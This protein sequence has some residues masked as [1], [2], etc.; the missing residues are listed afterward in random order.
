MK[1]SILGGVIGLAL[2]LIFGSD[3]LSQAKDKKKNDE[4]AKPTPQEYKQIQQA[5]ELE[6]KLGGSAPGQ[7]TLQLD[8]P[9]MEPN[10]KYNPGKAAN[11]QVQQMQGLYKQYLQALNTPNPYQRQQKLAKLAYQMNQMQKQAAQGTSQNSPFKVVNDYKD[12][13][14]PVSDKVVV[15][16]LN[17]GLEYD[18][19]GNIIQRTKEE[20]AKLKGKDPKVPGF[21]AKL[22]DLKTG[23]LVHLYLN[24]PP[25]AEKDQKDEGVGNTPRPTVR[26]IVILQDVSNLASSTGTRP[27]KS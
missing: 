21:A 6:G 24:P 3:G 27:K 15:R 2:M 20:I 4:G 9:Q 18:N 13:E 8:F 14:L 10:P 23:Q 5:K 11:N 16:K 19:E 12:F 7:L 17:L 25:K 22:E 26:M 1:L